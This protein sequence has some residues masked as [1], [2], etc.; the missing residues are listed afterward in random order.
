MIPWP[1]PRPP[2]NPQATVQSM[3]Y[4]TCHMSEI[5][6]ILAGT[7]CMG[8]IIWKLFLT[9]VAEGWR[10]P[11]QGLD[12]LLTQLADQFGIGIGI[13]L[14]GSSNQRAE[15]FEI[16]LLNLLDDFWVFL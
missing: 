8:R 2:D 4:A 1:Q 16:P 5:V 7:V 6:A 9:V 10:F 3:T 15:P 11:L 13:L 14:L 12:H